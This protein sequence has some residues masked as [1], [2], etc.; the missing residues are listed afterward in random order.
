VEAA[1]NQE[2]TLE[3]TAFPF[4]ANDDVVDAC[5]GA[6]L[7]CSPPPP[8]RPQVAGTRPATRPPGV[9]WPPP[10]LPRPY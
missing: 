7:K 6:F 9:Q 3:L 4:G 8:P 5:A 1:W 10:G 2:L